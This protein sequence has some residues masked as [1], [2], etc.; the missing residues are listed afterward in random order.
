MSGVPRHE[1]TD[2]HQ[3]FDRRLRQRRDALRLEPLGYQ[4]VYHRGTAGLV[5]QHDA[6]GITIGFHALD[7]V[8]RADRGQ[9]P[10]PAQI[11]FVYVPAQVF[12]A[13]AGMPPWNPAGVWEALVN[14]GAL[15]RCV[16]EDAQ[17]DYRA[18]QETSVLGKGWFG[19]VTT[20]SPEDL[21]G[22]GRRD[23][24]CCNL[25]WNGLMHCV[26]LHV[27]K[28]QCRASPAGD[29]AMEIRAPDEDE[30]P[31]VPDVPLVQAAARRDPKAVAALLAAKALPSAADSRGW[32]A[33]HAA[34][35]VRPCWEVLDQLIAVSDVCART[36]DGQLPVD[37][38]MSRCSDDV[39]NTLQT[40]MAE[41][42]VG[43]HLPQTTALS[44]AGMMARDGPMNW[45]HAAERG[46]RSR[47]SRRTAELLKIFAEMVFSK[48]KT[49][50]QAF[51]AIDV[52]KTGTLTAYEIIAACK[53]MSFPGDAT[54]VFKA[55]DLNM[56][57]DISLDEFSVLQTYHMQRWTGQD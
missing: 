26:A 7:L 25:P 51:E 42:R 4:S 17:P 9:L 20:L 1:S 14:H 44:A 19:L 15:R 24:T 27:L 22:R 45:N 41:H 40:H 2:L 13:V 12:D 16:E 47:D 11:V 39:V 30:V 56:M 49:V 29:G 38:A 10:E 33:L 21:R 28:R 57:G 52:N 3:Y 37:M 32:T 54:T 6:T 43:A 50:Q 8:E 36:L 31:G 34:C 18:Q 23:L 5:L 53:E 48:Y 35:S 46:R 55:L